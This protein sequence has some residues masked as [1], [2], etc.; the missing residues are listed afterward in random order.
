MNNDNIISRT[1]QQK[2]LVIHEKW[3]L[4]RT[5]VVHNFL[6]SQMRLSK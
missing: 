1:D 6:E 5:N 4:L 2:H 3:D